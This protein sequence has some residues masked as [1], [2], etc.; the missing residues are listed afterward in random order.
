MTTRV[1]VDDY[2]A[3]LERGHFAIEIM[4]SD[5][6]QVTV[7]DVNGKGG[8]LLHID[9]KGLVLFP[10]TG[11]AVEIRERPN[12][13]SKTAPKKHSYSPNCSLRVDVP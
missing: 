2:N 12:F 10:H 7:R 3:R 8:F 11:N 13:G 6:L 9:P 5:A 4:R 1:Y